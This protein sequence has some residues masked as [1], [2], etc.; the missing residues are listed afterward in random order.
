ML[1]HAWWTAIH[2]VSQS[3]SVG[4]CLMIVIYIDD[5]GG[6]DVWIMM[7]KSYPQRVI[8]GPEESNSGRWGGQLQGRSFKWIIHRFISSN[9]SIGRRGTEYR[10]GLG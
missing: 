6:G 5:D 8:D 1:M 2:R 9:L 10:G 3:D 4:I 7:V